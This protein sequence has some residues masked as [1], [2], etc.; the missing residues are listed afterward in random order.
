[1][2]HH[3]I[4]KVEMKKQHNQV[5]IR[6]TKVGEYYPLPTDRK[7]IMHHPHTHIA[8]LHSDETKMAPLWTKVSSSPF[9]GHANLIGGYGKRIQKT[10]ISIDAPAYFVNPDRVKI[11]ANRMDD[12]VASVTKKQLPDPLAAARVLPGGIGLLNA[13]KMKREHNRY[14]VFFHDKQSLIDPLLTNRTERE[15]IQ[16]SARVSARDT[17]YLEKGQ[18]HHAHLFDHSHSHSSVS[19]QSTTSLA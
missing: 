4:E 16:W 11:P 12:R 17:S 19:H 13:T 6:N 14:R 1:M 7:H 2:A 8:N 3:T 10:S 9:L 5:F 18:Q 15:P